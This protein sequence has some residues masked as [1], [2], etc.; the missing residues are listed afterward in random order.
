MREAMFDQRF[1]DAWLRLVQEAL[2][3][4]GA[5][6]QLLSALAQSPEQR[7]QW[8]AGALGPGAGNVDEW[9]EQWYRMMG[10][11]PR[12]R[13]LE[14]QDR[15]EQLRQRIE[16]MERQMSVLRATPADPTA[17]QR[18]MDS[19]NTMLSQMTALQTNWLQGGAR[20]P[21][22]DETTKP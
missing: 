3:G 5:A 7:R 6:Q 15:Y 21:S 2:R 14:L 16:D 18:L 13:Y 22:S 12:A 11:V 9:L 4:S 17:M 20:R 1:F 10:V 19:W 8:A